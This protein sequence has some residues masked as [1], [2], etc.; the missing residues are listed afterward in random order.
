MLKCKGYTK[1]GILNTPNQAV[2]IKL[3]KDRLLKDLSEYMLE[4]LEIFR[5]RLDINDYIIKD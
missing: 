5:N 2:I 3:D 1:C 4:Q